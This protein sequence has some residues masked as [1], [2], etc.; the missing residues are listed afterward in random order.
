MRS[1]TLP[2]SLLCTALGLALVSASPGATRL[3]S[4]LGLA[5]S[6]GMAALLPT[7]GV[8]PDAIFIGCWISVIA[9]AAIIFLRRQ[10][11]PY[12]AI[13]LSLN[14]GLWAG[15]VS[16]DSVSRLHSLSTLSCVLIWIPA[17]ALVARFGTV[18]IKVASSWIIAVAVMAATLQLLPVTP[19]YLPDHME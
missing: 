11:Q 17:S 16:S 7:S 18:P 9:T 13:A 1:G 19:G 15:M 6:A 4:L 14:A 3:R 5:G 2:V 8:S 12:V 10:L